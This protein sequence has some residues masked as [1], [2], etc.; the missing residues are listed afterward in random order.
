MCTNGP[1]GS[2]V[3]VGVGS[4]VLVGAVVGVAEGG[5]FAET[6]DTGAIVAGVKVEVGGA[7]AV[8]GDWVAKATTVGSV[9]GFATPPGVFVHANETV[10][11]MSRTARASVGVHRRTRTTLRIPEITTDNARV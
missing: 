1:S 9:G 8:A 10:A 6:V 3:A 2:G 4:A 11:T 5:E 7:V